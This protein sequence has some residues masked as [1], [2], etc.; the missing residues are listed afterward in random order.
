VLEVRDN[1]LCYHDKTK[2]N[3]NALDVTHTHT[4][5]EGDG[6]GEGEGEGKE[7]DVC[8]ICHEDVGMPYIILDCEHTLHEECF[9][10]F[11]TYELRHQKTIVTC[12]LCRATIIEVQA[13]TKINTDTSIVSDTNTNTAVDIESARRP[14]QRT[15]ESYG[16]MHNPLGRLFTSLCVEAGIVGVIVLIAY[17]SSCRGKVSCPGWGG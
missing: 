4:D 9:K 15:T 6:E 2:D 14:T 1:V 12:P 3:V 8:P 17:L 7:H 13:Q 16:F 10:E 11:I 5:D